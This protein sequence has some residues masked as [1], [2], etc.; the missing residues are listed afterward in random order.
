MD[1]EEFRAWRHRVGLTQQEA[2]DR[3]GVSRTAVQNWEGG[4]TPIPAVVEMSCQVWEDRLRQEDPKLGPVTLVYADGP[5]FIQ[6]Y[7]P[8]RRLA[9]MRQEPYPTNAA[10]L[11]RVLELWGR[12]DFH[13]PFVLD[14]GG[15]P[16]WNAIEL[17]RVV[18]GDDKAAPTPARWRAN[19]IRALADHFRSTS[20]I[21]VRSGPGMLSPADA[22]ELQRRIEG[23][24]AEIDTLAAD[25]DVTY[26]Q[27]EG[28]L[29]KLRMLGKHAPMQLVSD[30]ALALA[31]ER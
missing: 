30:V 6:A 2:A 10:A 27:V 1:N 11:G 9:M 29:M 14:E 8:Q 18:G 25:S 19:A 4:V 7:A 15:R 31:C 28:V 26:E 13:N 12:D 20:G 5:M 17:S 3:L 23:L 16:I 21:S 24:A 22:A